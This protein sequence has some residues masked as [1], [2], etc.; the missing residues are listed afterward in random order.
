P[1]RAQDVGAPSDPAALDAE[2]NQGM[3]ALAAE[4][5]DLAIEYLESVFESDPTYVS[6]GQ[7]AAAYW[8]GRAYEADD[9]LESAYEV[10]SEGIDALEDT[11]LFDLRLADVFVRHT[12]AGE[13]QEAYQRAARMYL[14][15]LGSLDR[16][17][18]EEIVL[19]LR[20]HLEMLVF[21]LP[22]SIQQQHGLDTLK[23]GS[24]L[25]LPEGTG[26]HLVTWW[27]S[28]DVAP[29]TRRNEF[30]EEHLRR[31]A[32]AEAHYRQRGRLDDRGKVYIR[33]GEPSHKTNI[34]FDS[35]RFR[36]KVV[37]RNLTLNMSD[38]PENEF[39]VYEHI[40]VAA[41]F[42]FYDSRGY[43]KLGEVMDLLPSVLRSGLN[44]SSRGQSKS[45]ALVRTMEEIY[46]M[47]AL[48]HPVFATRYQDVAAF[49]GL[50]DETE[51]MAQANATMQ[52][53]QQ[54]AIDQEGSESDL[55]EVIQDV[56][57]ANTNPGGSVGL[58]GTL[59]SPDRP[60]LFAQSMMMQGRVEDDQARLQ[61][62]E[63]VPPSYT[64]TFDEVEPLP[65]LVRT[66]RFLD[67]DGTTRTEVYWGA[68]T[69]AL[70]PSKRMVKELRK[71]GLEPR[72]Y[73]LIATVVQKTEAYQ[74]RVI[75]Y[76]R[77]VVPGLGLAEDVAL[78]PQS[79]TV[80]G[81]TATF[82]LALQWDQYLATLDGEGVLVEMG[83]QIKA[84]TFRVDTL[85]ALNND[86]NVLEVSDLKTMVMLDAELGIPSEE[87][88][89]TATI[90]P[91][92]IITPQTPL[93]LYFEAYHLAFGPDDQTHY[94]VEYEVRR[95]KGGGLLRFL[96]GGKEEGTSAQSRY[97]GSS[98]TAKEYILLDFS[99]WKG[100]GDL[101]VTVRITDGVTGR[102]VE[103]TL[104]F[105][106][107]KQ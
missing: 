36:N 60:D 1:V 85:Q 96:G 31:V 26:A 102:Q 92:T 106:L 89:E 57:A 66:A 71:E 34:S 40:D 56:L 30:L 11:G 90:Y 32:Y 63:H 33:L 75:N 91:Y 61:R 8:L 65:L 17:H 50:L 70:K 48:Y 27:R 52:A 78:E 68:P 74:D 22:E 12:F 49:S 77:H 4:Q 39:W 79:Y 54:A 38:F 100:K 105:T 2:F 88:L 7:G 84:N 42:L 94:T 53:N 6:P 76:Y 28:Q 55:P 67:P 104:A 25:Q 3:Q 13:E 21:I 20:Y 51:A 95:T 97:T 107:T 98:R 23:P 83:K 81:D 9:D 93:V 101:E 46:A 19:L 103:R 64:N 80:Q 18:P 15:L 58:T 47:L 29:A 24:P 43:Y 99:E 41:Q 69:D 87:L 86:A 35:T 37:D 72:S 73:L 62:E 10:W 5:A 59:F 45:R 14:A 44:A 82:H 16:P